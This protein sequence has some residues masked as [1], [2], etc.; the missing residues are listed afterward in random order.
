MDVITE[1]VD[2]SFVVWNMSQRRVVWNGGVFG[3]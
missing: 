2:W 3:G 1:L